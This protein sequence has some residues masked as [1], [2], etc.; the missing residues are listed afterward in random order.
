MPAGKKH[1][2]KPEKKQKKK[3]KPHAVYSKEVINGARYAKRIKRFI[4]SNRYFRS[5]SSGREVGAFVQKTLLPIITKYENG[6]PIT[7]EEIAKM[8]RRVEGFLAMK[9][10]ILLRDALAR[11]RKTRQLLQI[12]AVGIPSKRREAY[13]IIERLDYLLEKVSRR[14][15]KLADAIRILNLCEKANKIK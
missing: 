5:V 3:P 12:K 7:A 13:F 14:E 4:T 1:V 15:A 10:E 6:K 9:G 8:R 2:E 11:A